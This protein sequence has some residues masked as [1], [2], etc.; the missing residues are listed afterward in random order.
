MTEFVDSFFDI[1]YSNQEIN[2]MWFDGMMDDDFFSDRLEMIEDG[3]QFTVEDFSGPTP[4]GVF[5]FRIRQTGDEQSRSSEIVPVKIRKRIDKA[6]PLL[7]ILDDDDDGDSIPTED[8][9]ALLDN[10]IGAHNHMSM[11]SSGVC[12]QFFPDH[13]VDMCSM[14][15][16][17]LVSDGLMIEAI[18]FRDPDDDGDTI[19]LIIRI[20]QRPDT[21][22]QE[23]DQLVDAHFY[24]DNDGNLVVE[25]IKGA[26]P[27]FDDYQNNLLQMVL[28]SPDPDDQACALLSPES[29]DECLEMRR[30]A[31]RNGYTYMIEYSEPID[32]VRIITISFYDPAGALIGS[33]EYD[34]G[35]ETGVDCGGNCLYVDRGN[36]GVNPLYV[37]EQ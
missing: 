33:A 15:R 11:L 6:T 2:D 28:E 18:D 37:E 35:F 26:N 14:D 32:E 27:I 36:R 12:M 19:G 34:N 1:T 23:W 29:I 5:M 13:R 3:V 24:Y 17:K 4:D 20:R 22:T 9:R 25:F 16:D 10:Y 8:K 7:I 21:L 30:L 31:A